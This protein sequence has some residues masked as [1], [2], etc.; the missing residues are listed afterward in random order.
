MS[1]V[2]YSTAIGRLSE[3]AAAASARLRALASSGH[4]CSRLLWARR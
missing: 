1:A 4:Q 2:K 3:M